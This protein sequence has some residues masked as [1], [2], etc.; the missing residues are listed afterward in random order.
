MGSKQAPATNLHRFQ[1]ND[2]QPDNKGVA[3][4]P[5]NGRQVFMLMRLSAGVS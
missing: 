2:F 1:N 4:L 3:E 5:L